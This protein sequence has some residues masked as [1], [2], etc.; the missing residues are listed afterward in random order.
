M[1]FDRAI[2]GNSLA[3]LVAAHECVRCGVPVALVNGS[4]GWGGHFTTINING[5]PFDLGMV[6]Q[7]F[8]SFAAQSPIESIET[9]S[10]DVRND[11]G[12]YTTVV[13]DYV[14]RF[15]HTVEVKTPQMQYDGR[16]YD[17]VLIANQIESF[18]RLP[19][20]KSAAR[21]LQTITSQLAQRTL[22]PS[23]KTRE[24][25]FLKASFD[26]VS[27]ANHGSTIHDRL[28]EPACLKL[29]NRASMDVVA[30]YH[31]AAWL[32]LYYPESLLAAITHLNPRMPATFFS[33]PKGGHVGDLSALLVA[34]ISRSNNA[35]VVPNRPVE[36]RYLGSAGYELVFQNAEPMIFS[37]VA[38][39]SSA[40]ELLSLV[41]RDSPLPQYE[42]TSI[43]LGFACVDATEEGVDFS[44]LNVPQAEFATTR[45]TNQ[46]RCSGKTSG[47]AHIVLECNPEYLQRLPGPPMPLSDRFKAELLELGV[48]SDATAINSLEVRELSNV[49]TVPSFRNLEAQ[50]TE[51]QMIRRTMPNLPLLGPSS[52]F[53]TSSFNDQIV[54]GLRL[55]RQWGGS[56]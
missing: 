3:A 28:M 42:K 14:A 29:L 44:V 35:M 38:W 23:N 50:Q 39:A 20:S 40:S 55:A 12:R 19:F 54:Q 9:Y 45:I 43:A 27:R 56:A 1:Q 10:P 21:D 24:P 8:T 41:D 33:Y 7:E 32:P 53:F 15:Q 17:D 51:A 13:K 48:V 26:E 6:L 18:G 36:L 16:R 49:L 37:R 34:E 30:L 25:A 31:R 2:I 11:V 5:T 47:P 46:S 4:K 22:H 52:G